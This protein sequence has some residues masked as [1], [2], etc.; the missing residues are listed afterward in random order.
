[1]KV[2]LQF[3]TDWK[4]FVP[5]GVAIFSLLWSMF[6]F[7]A[8]RIITVKLTQID[9]KHLK[10]DVEEL[11]KSD[12]EYKVDLREDLNKIFKRLGRIEKAQG[13]QKAICNERHSKK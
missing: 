9:L 6:N 11:K 3:L 13:I 1:M 10:I 7:I 12:K 2:Q 4:F 5:M 8:G